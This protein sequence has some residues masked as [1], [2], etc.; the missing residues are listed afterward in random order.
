[1]CGIL[2]R[3]SKKNISKDTF[4]KLNDMMSHRGPDDSG[5]FIISLDNYQICLG[6]RRLSILDLS[7]L[8]H[9]PMFSKDK[10]Q[11]IIF[12]GE[13]YNF[14]EIREQLYSLGHNF[15]SG[16][17]TE[18]ILEAYTEWGKECF[19]KFN[20]MFA[21][22]L[23][24]I[25]KEQLILARD[26]VGKKPLY[27]YWDQTTFIF[28]SEMKP[29]L[30]DPAIDIKIDVSKMGQYL[31]Y[32]YVSE[33]ETLI[34][35]IKKVPAGTLLIWEKGN[36]CLEKYWDL[37]NSFKENNK[38]LET[39]YQDAKEHLKCLLTD[40]VK[41]RLVADVPV[42]IFLSG[43]IDSSLVAAIAKNA[44]SEK[45]RTFCIGFH[46]KGF[47]EALYASAVAKYLG[48]EHHEFYV[49]DKTVIEMVNDLPKYFDEPMADSSQIP[50][51]LVS[52]FASQYVKVVLSGD[53]GD[54]LFCG[55]DEYRKLALIREHE[56][57]IKAFQKF[58]PK[59]F[60]TILPQKAENLLR[61]EY[62]DKQ[63]QFINGVKLCAIKE[64]L[65]S[66]NLMVLYDEK[67]Y[68]D[69]DNKVLGKML[70]DMQHYLVDDILI[71]TD[72][73]SMR[74]SIEARCPLLDYRIMEYSFRLPMKFKLQSSI[75]K[76]I[77]RDI[78][79]DYIDKKLFE[80]PKS[81][82]AFP[83]KQYLFGS[84]KEEL[85]DLSNTSFIKKENLFDYCALQK[86]INGAINT[87]DNTYD[88]I[89]WAYYV[90]QKWYREYIHD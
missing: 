7:P 60:A 4:C 77:L 73:S 43:G 32:Q 80:R 51:M 68:Q 36:L 2:G 66:E 26:R 35:N 74:Y 33:N 39:N 61:H 16:T 12:N 3:L 40:S 79:G 59:E 53:G 52:K 70:I 14:Q 64:L 56:F 17:D 57:S 9:Q 72:R 65:G 88:G 85:L 47:N 90:F 13:V 31:A 78:L 86:M 55:Y 30:R 89:L 67:K 15:K 76:V 42:G 34:K 62:E 54:E 24:D 25:E 19:A 11:V 10:N 38:N 84:L 58:F 23:L 50:T 29:I 75:G 48:S 71:K 83:I 81:G 1:M 21:I 6:H 8:G 82:F 5:V 49:D 27:Y 18:V 46:E 63:F 87:N 20:G 28:A 44:A 22:G 37:L 41:K 69:I 45:I